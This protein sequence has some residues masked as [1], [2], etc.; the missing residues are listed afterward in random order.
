MTRCSIAA[1]GTSL[2]GCVAARAPTPTLAV[3]VHRPD[4]PLREGEEPIGIPGRSHVVAASIERRWAV[5]SQA[6]TDTTGDGVV[7]SM[8]DGQHGFEVADQPTTWLVLGTGSGEAIEEFYGS[9]GDERHLVFSDEGD[10]VVLDIESGRRDRLGP[11]TAFTLWPHFEPS[12]SAS[13][14]SRW[15]VYRRSEREAVLYDP[16][17]RASTVFEIPSGWLFRAEVVRNWLLAEVLHRAP[18]DASSTTDI[19]HMTSSAGDLQCSLVDGPCEGVAG[20]V[21]AFSLEHP[22][23]QVEAGSYGCA[24]ASWAVVRGNEAGELELVWPESGRVTPVGERNCQAR[25]LTLGEDPRYLAYRCEA[26]PAPRVVVFG[27]DEATPPRDESARLEL[28]VEAWEAI[29]VRP[30]DARHLLGLR[31][32][33]EDRV[34]FFAAQGVES[35]PVRPE[36]PDVRSTLSRPRRCGDPIVAHAPAS[37]CAVVGP[38]VEVIAR[39]PD[40]RAIARVRRGDNTPACGGDDT[41][42]VWTHVVVHP[43][44]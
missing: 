3:P 38:D 23:V 19:P 13:V 11:R 2:L 24:V 31:R 43:A 33:T 12:S 39:L 35:A 18:S 20:N 29:G 28:G 9:T 10:V 4:L 44:Q 14:G 34:Y 21:L 32:A 40:G 7:C 22:S 26:S 17:T 8:T 16:E 30:I 25:L 27:D 42:V 5:L 6:R 15:V 36:P 41:Q 1:V 37:P